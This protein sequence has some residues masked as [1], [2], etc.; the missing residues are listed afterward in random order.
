MSDLA[1]FDFSLEFSRQF[2]TNVLQA[3]F[4]TQATPGR[5]SYDQL[6]ASGLI[7]S[8]SLAGGSALYQSY[9][10]EIEAGYD[11]TLAKPQVD[12][13]VMYQ[14]VL[15][16]LE[17]RIKLPRNIVTRVFDPS[18]MDTG[19]ADNPSLVDVSRDYPEE[20]RS[21]PRSD[22]Y[23]GRNE[24]YTSGA[25]TIEFPPA[26]T[27]F[28]LGKRVFAQT[29]GITRSNVTAVT[30]T[31][32][33]VSKA[34]QDFADNF[35]A[36]VFSF[37]I[38][39]EA[40]GYDL[41]PMIGNLTQLA[42]TVKEPTTMRIGLAPSG[43]VIAYAANIL[44]LGNTGDPS[45]LGYLLDS[46]DFCVSF[47]EAMF[48]EIIS[49]LYGYDPNFP[50]AFDANGS[51]VNGGPVNLAQPRLY[52]LAGGLQLTFG[53][54]EGGPLQNITAIVEC[55][56]APPS[57]IRVNLVSVNWDSGPQ[58]L[59][60]AGRRLLTAVLVFHILGATTGPV[61]SDILGA[62]T[63]NSLDAGL[64]EFLRT[65]ALAFGYRTPIRGTGS[66]VDATPIDIRFRQGICTFFNS[67]VIS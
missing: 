60:D 36:K 56:S 15:V 59:N 53:V 27:A 64:S 37:V 52:F 63:H 23:P 4:K 50:I 41:T 32:G 55:L 5:F 54:H 19:L 38:S 43:P 12:F 35:A 34:M 57:P 2:A 31:L 8:R 28:G 25:I 65:S 42:I 51:P 29:T 18:T 24:P 21:A 7:G 48:N 9:L 40:D 47:S 44:P 14:R 10:S 17:L 33:D 67:I 26:V 49:Y 39:K 20:F 61:L 30:V 58:I 22:P 45:Q 11:L 66:F 16:R 46:G 62:S 13:D 1:N 3:C 6:G